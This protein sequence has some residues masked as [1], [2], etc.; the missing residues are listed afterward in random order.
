ML[1]LL[2]LLRV[3]LQPARAVRSGVETQYGAGVLAPGSL[4]SDPLDAISLGLALMFGTAGLPHI[5][6]RFYTVPDAQD[7]AHVG[8][9]RDGASSASSTC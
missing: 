2:V 4:V 3:R 9:L 1:A 8:R 5:L 6:M 7:G